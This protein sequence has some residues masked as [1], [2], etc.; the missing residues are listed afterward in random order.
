MAAL[1]ALLV[2]RELAEERV[3]IDLITPNSEFVYRPMELAALFRDERSQRFD[4]KRIAADQ[5]ATLVCDRLE[6]VWPDS[7]AVTSRR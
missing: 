5:G 6:G 7:R 4:L 2:L 3:E 1:E